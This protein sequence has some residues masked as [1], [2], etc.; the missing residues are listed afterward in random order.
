M[1]NPSTR[2]ISQVVSIAALRFSQLIACILM[3]SEMAGL[4]KAAT[5]TV[6][7]ILAAVLQGCGCNTSSVQNNCGRSGGSACEEITVFMNCVKDS[8]CCDYLV[9]SNSNVRVQDTFEFL[10]DVPDCTTI[11]EIVT[12]NP[13][14]S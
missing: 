11:V 2:C 8:G 9:D 12:N 4:S 6:M 3:R 1:R 13:C 14:K 7:A 10:I 5:V